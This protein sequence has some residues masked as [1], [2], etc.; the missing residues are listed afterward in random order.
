MRNLEE[1]LK[2]R[3][4]NYKSLIKYGFK[5]DDKGYLF[6]KDILDGSFCVL[7]RV[8]ENE[9]YS[10]VIEKDLEEEYV[11]VDVEEAVGEFVGKVRFEYENVLKDMIEKC[12][13]LELFKENQTKEIIQAVYDTWGDNLEF[14]W[15]KFESTAIV[16]NK[17]TEKWYG[18]FMR[19]K[20]DRL[21]IDSEKEVEVLNVHYYKDKTQDVVD[22]KSVFLG[23]HMNKKSWLSIILDGSLDN[24]KIMDFL[25]ISYD[26]AGGDK[27]NTKIDEYSKK[28]YEYLTLIPR[29]KVVTYG[30]IAK[31]LG[32]KGLSR[33]VGTILHNNPDGDKYPC[34]KVLNGKGTLAE[35]FV[36]GGAEIQKERLEKE[37]IEV[38]DNKVDLKKYQWNE[39][40]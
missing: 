28:V 23:Y 20:A 25:K 6:E 19:I 36:F 40:K 32:N 2:I 9:K 4:I 18:L 10:K 13:E 38:K 31:Y 12:T 24:D 29:G 21:G 39:G 33:I 27:K 26:L 16:R 11:L 15:D 30:Q 3:T 8:S 35:K 17:N 14:L 5:K 1:Y 34:Y 22:N 37:G 7:I